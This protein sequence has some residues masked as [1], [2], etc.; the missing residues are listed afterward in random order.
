MSDFKDF[1]QT[2]L[3]R[4]PTTY[5]LMIVGAGYGG[6]EMCRLR[7]AKRDAGASL[8][9]PSLTIERT[10]DFAVGALM[11]TAVFFCAVWFLAGL[12][13]NLNAWVR[14]LLLAFAY[15][16]LILLWHLI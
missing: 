3:F 8:H 9:W 13:E 16:L 5:I 11:M 6:I 10:V 7:E 4:H 1:L 12:V 2:R 14:Q 15:L